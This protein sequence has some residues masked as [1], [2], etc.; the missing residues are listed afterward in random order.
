MASILGLITVNHK[1]ILEVDDVPSNAAGTSAPLGSLALYDNG[2]TSNLYLKTGALDTQ[3]TVLDIDNRDW[4]LLGNALTGP[5]SSSPNEFLGSTNDY[6]L[7]FRRNAAEIMRLVNDGLLIGLNATTGGRLQIATAT[8][9]SDIIKQIS[10]NGGS[11][12]N[13]I[14]VTRQSKVQTTN[15]AATTLFD[16]AV[17][18]D[19]VVGIEAKVVCRQH[20]GTSGSPGD[21]AYYVR[22]IHAR[23]IG[24]AVS[25]RQNATSVTS[26]DVGAFNVVVS[27]SGA[28]VRL[29]AVGTAGRNIAWF[30]HI[31]MLIAVD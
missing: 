29:E 20:S 21:G 5:L 9:G 27:A 22:N 10:P 17:P 30:A 7:I 8:L 1:Q 6:D 18:N 23:N 3:W 12:A 24:G 26:E 16:I 19:S 31:E 15:A 2:T 13:V 11:G 25:I 4:S 14:H 28:N